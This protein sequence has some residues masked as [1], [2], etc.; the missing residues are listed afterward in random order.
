MQDWQAS[1]ALSLAPGIW[2]IRV[3]IPKY[4]GPE[5]N[6]DEPSCPFDLSKALS[7][8]NPRWKALA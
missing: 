6:R 3:F 7:N 2:K 4:S 8:P 5:R 1:A